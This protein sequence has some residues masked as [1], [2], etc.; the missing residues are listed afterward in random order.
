MKME[1]KE[2]KLQRSGPLLNCLHSPRKHSQLLSHV[3]DT[4]SPSSQLCGTTTPENGRCGQ[5][6]RGES[7]RVLKILFIISQRSP[8]KC[9]VPTRF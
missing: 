3:S 6:G 4:S 2:N 5:E 7:A 9:Q 8:S 1:R